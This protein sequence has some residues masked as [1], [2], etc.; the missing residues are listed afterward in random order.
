MTTTTTRQPRKIEPD[1]SDIAKPTDPVRSLS[2]PPWMPADVVKRIEAFNR[3]RIELLTRR[4]TTLDTIDNTQDAIYDG[5]L[6]MKHIT[7]ADKAR[8][9]LLIYDAQEAKLCEERNGLLRM[10]EPANRAVRE[11]IRAK[12]ATRDSE[13]E[14]ESLASGEDELV[15]DA[16][17][18][19]DP[20]LLALFASMPPETDVRGIAL[21]AKVSDERREHLLNKL[22]KHFTV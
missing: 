9:S 21:A 14:A 4:A 3:R 17:L 11:E 18:K 7:A 10:F 13:I 2:A 5:T 16:R 8:A 15:T 1:Y 20:S 22:S 12:V 6:T 19:T